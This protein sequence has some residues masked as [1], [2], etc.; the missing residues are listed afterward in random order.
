[1]TPQPDSGQPA[2]NRLCQGCYAGQGNNRATSAMIAL[3]RLVALSLAVALSM[4]WTFVSF[5]RI[6]GPPVTTNIGPPRG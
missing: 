2:H 4:C 6:Y 5:T 3:L 1:M